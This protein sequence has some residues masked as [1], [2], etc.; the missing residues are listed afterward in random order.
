MTGRRID[1]TLARSW[2]LVPALTHDA[3]AAAEASSVDAII[4]DLEDGVPAG[5][6][7]QARAVAVEWLQEHQGWVRINDVSTMHWLE[8]VRALREAPGLL[9]VM[10][11][12]SETAHQI[13][14]TAAQLPRGTALIALVESA[15]GMQAA[16]SIAAAAGVLRIAFG[17]G[18]FRRDT[19]IG[20]SPLAL[21]YARS[22][23]VIASRAAGIAAPIDG[24]TLTT[25]DDVLRAATAVTADM[26]MAGKLCL[27][28]DQA[29]VINAQLSPGVTDLRWARATV[30]RLGE[31]GSRV[32]DGSDLPQLARA[33]LLLKH[34]KDFG[35]ELPD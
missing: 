12:K 7:A 9:G 16:D 13:A 32:T 1:P 21:A 18:D 14:D 35:V 3:L 6:K 31:D 24:P 33:K 11:A 27:Q 15:L 29:A 17:V 34:A 26:G 10:L 19:G 22:H 28:T 25:D 20:D 2:L 4:L 23:L 8:D 5:E 30:D